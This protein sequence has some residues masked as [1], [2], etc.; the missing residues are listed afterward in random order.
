MAA[1]KTEKRYAKTAQGET[2]NSRDIVNKENMLSTKTKHDKT[3]E[4]LSQRISAILKVTA[5][6][7][8]D[9]GCSTSL[10]Q[11]TFN[12]KHNFEKLGSQPQITS[13]TTDIEFLKLKLHKKLNEQLNSKDQ[14]KDLTSNVSV[15]PNKKKLTT[16]SLLSNRQGNNTQFNE[17]DNF[18]HRGNNEIDDHQH[19]K[20]LS[21]STSQTNLQRTVISV[22][23]LRERSLKSRKSQRSLCNSIAISAKSTK[24]I[25]SP[26]VSKKEDFSIASDFILNDFSA[27]SMHEGIEYRSTQDFKLKEL[28]S[29]HD[30]KQLEAFSKFT[31]DVG[32][33]RKHS[34]SSIL[35]SAICGESKDG[36]K[37]MRL[38]GADIYYQDS[39]LSEIINFGVR[40]RLGVCLYD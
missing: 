35:P 15:S 18:I 2:A 21:R 17:L 9:H 24:S 28:A 10:Q 38:N 39:I 36:R 26:I 32:D 30:C 12:Q 22:S 11:A 33:P 5:S 1:L 40:S 23:E 29:I 25:K 34:L 7:N 16:F 3:A 4:E 6:N 27:I 37:F 14:R 13:Y 20:V 19:P 31:R 8:V